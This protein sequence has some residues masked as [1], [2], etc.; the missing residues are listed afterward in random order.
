MTHISIFSLAKPRSAPGKSFASLRL[1]EG[2]NASSRLVSLRLDPA[3]DYSRV[4]GLDDT[5]SWY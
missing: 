4:A 5:D 3:S 1:G 2:L